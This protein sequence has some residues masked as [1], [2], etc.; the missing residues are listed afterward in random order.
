MT[1]EKLK[2]LYDKALHYKKNHIGGGWITLEINEVLNL[3]EEVQKTKAE[4]LSIQNNLKVEAR[5]TT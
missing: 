4:L 3:L 1:E 5:R 2:E